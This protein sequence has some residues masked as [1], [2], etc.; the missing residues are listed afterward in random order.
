MENLSK[1]NNYKSLIV[2]TLFILFPLS[3]I[4]GNFFINLNIFLIILFTSIFYSQKLQNINFNLTDKLITL[5]FIYTFCVLLVNFFDAWFKNDVLSSI[6][7]SKTFFYLRYYFLYISLRVLISQN[8]LSLKWFYFSCIFF[9]IFVSVDIFIQYYFGENL[10]G[11]EPVSRLKYSG[12]FGEE[13]IAGGYILRFCIFAF[14]MPVIF[15]QNKNWKKF[16]TLLLLLVI[17]A[18]SILLSGNRMPLLLFCLFFLFFLII[19]S[20]MRK[21]MILIFIILTTFLSL[22]YFNNKNIKLNYDGFVGNVQS[23]FSVYVSKEVSWQDDYDI[24][25]TPYAVEIHCFY[26]VWKKNPYFGGGIKSYRVNTTGCNTHPHNYFFEILDDLGFF[27]F[28]IFLAIIMSIYLNL[29][30]RKNIFSMN[31]NFNLKIL[32]SFCLFFIEFFPLRVSGSFFSTNNAT[33]VFIILAL[34][35]SLIQFTEEKVSKETII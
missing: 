4:L 17:F 35:I 24:K 21:Y 13:L 27:G 32:P 10:F 25:K 12:V 16:L 11:I 23:L 15:N 8:I 9:S 5:F 30:S 28:L 33:F 29:F 18:S 2:N 26:F 20:N 19:N 6:I 3:F 22:S 14:F 34:L 7:I 31:D 1:K